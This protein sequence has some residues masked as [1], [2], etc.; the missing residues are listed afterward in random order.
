MIVNQDNLTVETA[1]K[2]IDD[3]RYD[4]DFEEQLFLQEQ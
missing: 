2:W 1:E 4:Q 3:H